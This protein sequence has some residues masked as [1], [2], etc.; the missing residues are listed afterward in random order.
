MP[1][2]GREAAV[3]QIPG[4]RRH[5]PPERRGLITPEQGLITKLWHF[6]LA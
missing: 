2:F 4:P 3:L 5:P 1:V 6:L